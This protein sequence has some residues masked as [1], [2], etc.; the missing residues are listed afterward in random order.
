M[1]FEKREGKWRVLSKLTFCIGRFFDIWNVHEGRTCFR[2]NFLYKFTA[3]IGSLISIPLQRVQ[4]F[5]HIYRESFIYFASFF[6]AQRDRLCNSNLSNQLRILL[7]TQNSHNCRLDTNRDSFQMGFDSG[8]LCMRLWALR[9]CGI[10][11]ET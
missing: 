3:W 10:E 8:M 5:C 4:Y 11:A 2:A 7:L 9:A 6:W 1:A